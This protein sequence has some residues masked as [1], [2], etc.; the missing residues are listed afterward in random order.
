M[1]K[2]SR[3]LKLLPVLVL[4]LV[5]LTTAAMAA[6]DAFDTENFV[7]L[8][9][10]N[11]EP[12]TV[13]VTL[14][15]GF[16]IDSTKK[17]TP[18]YTETDA[19]GD[20]SYYYEVAANSRYYCVAKP[21]SGYAR[22]N[23]QRCI[24]ITETEAT[25]KTVMDVT[26]PKRSTNGWDPSGAVLF[27]TD[28][29]MQNIYKSDAALW[30]QYAEMFTTPAFQSGRNKHKQTTQTEM[31]NFINGLDDANDNMHVYIIG[32]SAGASTYEQFDIP[33][34]LFT[35]TDLS[36]ATTLEEAAELVKANGKLTVH[37]QAQIH[38]DEQG[39]GE[40]ALGM[41]KRLDGEYGESLLDT[42]NIYVI[43][44]L[45]PRG[46]YK[47][48]RVSYLNGS[49]TDPNRDFLHLAT[50]EVQA[51]MKVYNLFEPEVVF[52]NHEY[53]VT[54]EYNR[55]KW[56]DMSL[57]C[58]PLFN[59]TE[60]YQ[61][62]AVEMAFAAFNQLEEDGLSYRWY[63]DSVG[64]L[65]GNTG[66]SNTAFRGSIHI[67]METDG[68]DR[69]IQF[70][71]R[72]VAA[73]AS[74]VSGILDYLDENA[75]EVQKVVRAQQQLLVEKGRTYEEED[76]LV[77]NYKSADR[78]DL[79][80]NG[81]Y[82]LLDS[83]TIETKTVEFTASYPSEIT[84][85]RVAPTAY[86]IPANADF[87]E[88]VLALMDKHGIAY[89]EL[90]AGA[91]VNLQQYNLV[92]EDEGG[93]I[94]EASLSDE[95]AV[96]FA[97]GAYVL[98]MAQ[99]DREI[100]ACLMEPDMN[101]V[102]SQKGSL[103]H[104][105]I[106]TD[107]DGVFPIYR[108]IH[109]LDENDKIAYSVNTFD[110]ENFKGL[111][112]FTTVDGISV[113]LY[114]GY[115]EDAT[116]MTPVHTEGNTYY[117]EVEAGGKYYY[118]A[119]P[120][121]G[122][123]RYNIRKNIYITAEEATQKIV[124]DVTPQ[125]RST[126]G[127]DPYET[128]KYYSDETMA[129]AFPSSPDLW[130]AYKDLLATPILTIERNPHKHTTQTEM[131][132]YINGLDD[133]D[134]NMYVFV[135]GKSGGSTASQQFDI[136]VVFFT[137]TDLSGATTWEEAATLL[138]ENGKLSFMYQAQI[139][140][141]EIGSGE[142]A[143]AMLKHF[144]GTY[145]DGLL[146][147]MNIAMIPRL[148]TW[149]AYKSDRMVYFNGE[150]IDP[151]RDFMKLESAEAQLSVKLYN[152]LEP[153]LFYDAHECFVHPEYN[154][155]D[156]HDVWS[157]V[158]FVPFTTQEFKDTALTLADKIFDRAAKNN[159]TY[160]WYSSSINGY[161]TVMGTTNLHVRGSLV[162][163][164]ES[165][166]ILG[167]NQQ[168]ERRIMSHVS[169]VTGV[170]DYVNE[171]VADVQKVVDDQ[172][173][174]IIN[175]GKTYDESDVIVLETGYSQHP[176]H[177]ISGKKV[178]TG[179][180]EITDSVFTGVIYDVVKNS[181]TAPTAY[182]IPAGESWTDGVLEL[183]D[184]QGIT[185]TQIP[186]AAVQLQQY[187]GTVSAASLTEE[188]TVVFPEG[189]YVMTMAQ[190]NAYIL[191][192]LMEPDVK[193]LSDDKGTMAQQG[194]I[195]ATDGVFPIYRYIHDLNTD[196]TITYKTMF[197]APTG[198]SVVGVNTLGGAGKITGL[199]ASKAYEYRAEGETVYT[200]VA[201]G[202]TEI[203]DLPLGTYKVRFAATATNEVSA[204]TELVVNYENLTSVV[205]YVDGSKGNN[206]NTGFTANDPLKY[207]TKAD[208]ILDAL[209][210]Y[211][212]EGVAAKIVLVG[213]VTIT[214]VDYKMPEHDYPLVITSKTGA[215]GFVYNAS[216]NNGKRYFAMGGDTT[217][218]NLT[219]T[220]K[221]SGTDNYLCAAGYKLT[222]ESSVKTVAN[223]SGN[224]FNLMVGRSSTG[225]YGGELVVKGGTWRY[226]YAGAYQT[227]HHDSSR[228]VLSDCTISLLCNSY[229]YTTDGDIY[230][231]LRNVTVKEA[232]YCGNRYS[233][234][235]NG[236]VTLVLGEGVTA[237]LI[238]AGSKVGNI[239]GKVTVIAD[240]IDLAT[241]TIYGKSESSSG[242]IGSL[243]LVVNQ[244]ELADVAEDFITK[245]GTEIILGCD[246]TKTATIPYSINLDLNGCNGNI[247]VADGKTAT[248]CDT[249]T[250]DF[251]VLDEQGYGILTATGTVVAKDGYDT[252]EE[253]GGT[254][255]HRQ[256]IRLNGVTLRPTA[257][258]I[259]Y[260]GQFGLNE[261]YREN[262]ECYGVVLS[263]K[264]DPALDKEDCIWSE[265][266]TWS[267]TGAGYG[268]VLTGI[269][270]KDGGYSTNRRNADMVVYGVAYIKYADGTVEY[271]NH[272]SYTLKQVVEASDAMWSDL[273]ETQKNGLLDMYADFSNVMKAWNIPN[274]KA[275]Q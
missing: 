70:Y 261:L 229:N 173:A 152:Q 174:D 199:D 228:V 71:E 194:L 190:K 29:T 188:K 192:L 259:Y 264:A 158:N 219:I 66:S 240:G 41:I 186:A 123:S 260:N 106:I 181:R 15:S 107:T 164:T 222:I 25:Q 262:V 99:V 269:M 154:Q 100:L 230:M 59:F 208:E 75:K 160:G 85:S 191:G 1:R 82:I 272:A 34:V 61:N 149:G 210:P 162:F 93:L 235:V 67:L 236:N 197:A 263:L 176:E 132:N 12:E 207:I 9:L 202:A 239:T 122:Y 249:A 169:T 250:D 53:Q 37:Y 185:Y 69:G 3:F 111:V 201:A 80:L 84:R 103:V 94:T 148:N 221:T 13:T 35:T 180:G 220:L 238:Y 30:P 23:E 271:S 81:K 179:S 40:A 243:K 102:R 247:V 57:C 130:P 24:Y 97:G 204:D 126:A 216:A 157:C 58:H 11:T 43:P 232:I 113:K 172:R 218:E 200:A 28:E 54:T 246:Q 168:I 73:H 213:N 31:M 234:H 275:A 78:E 116:L 178:D 156:M 209:M 248:V 175:R 76:V 251:K 104:Q 117:Y 189:A 225:A 114:K 44:R 135:L 121:S 91:T 147:N 39:A 26:P 17:Q 136:P 89:Y 171:N 140:G 257:A 95:K 211:A 226:V 125:I 129:A 6:D 143:L 141:K 55:I 42:M 50:P 224:Y 212:A 27:Y 49:T 90:P 96:T 108:Y 170:L 74:A 242:T 14:Y 142:A 274:I 133:A 161:N 270:T 110:T 56:K 60:D 253:V 241:N 150:E 131:M 137:E 258:G 268:T 166:G 98:T 205:L 8:V 16:A 72:R 255:Y 184:K 92:S 5:L 79:H 177:N 223:S 46:A 22:Y 159:L 254:S 20:V 165:Q 198:L 21:T 245:D 256:T 109:D 120:S 18:V 51:R 134:D 244:G 182:V 105:G 115:T 77:F 206:T 153:E 196:G 187:T 252:R 64:G 63:D 266:K 167:G 68:C 233:N 183:L 38:G 10:Q 237:P 88:T 119:R 7:G 217:M 118:N 101:I 151:N 83:G 62:T 144:D 87:T 231:E 19:N 146:E 47:S 128:V 273:T 65:G 2:N 214:T 52:D 145:G 138:R 33:M 48:Q 215:E 86:V 45:N 112:L 139:H 127:W 4:V 265:L 203:A 193:D 227:P 155:V 36:S 195:T 124:L 163:L 32:K 267:E